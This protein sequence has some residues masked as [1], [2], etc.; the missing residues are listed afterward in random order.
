MHTCLEQPCI[1]IIT[2]KMDFHAPRK[3][4]ILITEMSPDSSFDNLLNN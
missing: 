4:L 1:S 2:T 3:F